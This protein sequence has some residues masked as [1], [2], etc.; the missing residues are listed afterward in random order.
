MVRGQARGPIVIADV[1]ARAERGFAQL[2]TDQD[3]F[4]TAAEGRA[5]RQAMRELRRDRMI[6]G[7]AARQAQRQASPPGP[8]SE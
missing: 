6:A 2:D 4:V 7:R 5:G 8:A 3:G 1:Q